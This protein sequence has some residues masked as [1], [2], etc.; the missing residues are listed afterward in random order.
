MYVNVAAIAVARAAP[1]PL[2]LAPSPAAGPAS[3][4][5]CTAKNAK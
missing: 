5:I 3:L 4:F 2:S 1:L